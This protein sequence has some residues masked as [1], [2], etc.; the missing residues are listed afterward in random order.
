MWQAVISGLTL[1]IV[2]ALSVGP[3]IFTII[4]QSLHSGHKGGLSFVA[5]VWASDIILVVISNLFSELVGRLLIYKKA[6]GVIGSIFLLTMG[7]LYVFFRKVK[8]QSD[9]RSALQDVSRWEMVKI[10]SSGFLI[11][12]LNPNVIIFWLG[13]ATA[14]AGKFAWAERTLVFSVCLGVNILAD[15]L[16]VI[17]AGQLRS[18]L[19][20]QTINVINKIS[21]SLLILFGVLL[22]YGTYYL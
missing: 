3:V 21:G 15:F 16:K 5:G 14:F 12:T 13:T 2:L 11:N 22:F 20:L 8:L 7:I 1:G 9:Q 17:L 6:I 18:R 4:K 19:T 10:F